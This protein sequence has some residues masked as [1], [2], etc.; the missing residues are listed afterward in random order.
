MNGP[1]FFRYNSAALYAGGPSP[2]SPNF[3]SLV[4]AGLE[5]IQS[6]N[7]SFS[8]PREDLFGWDGGGDQ[9]LIDRPRADL[10]FS[11]VFT[12]GQVER[13][14][15]FVVGALNTTSALSNLN[16]ER[17]YY[18]LFNQGQ[19]DLIG[20][21][22]WD[23][24]V[25]AF[26]NGVLTRYDFAA[27]VGQPTTCNA[28]V[29]CLNLAIQPSGTGQPLPAVYKQSGNY[30]TGLYALPFAQKTISEFAEAAPRNI[31]LTFDT[32]CAIGALLSGNNA[33]PLQSFGF[34]IDV[35]R[36]DIRS[37]GWA[38]PDTRSVTWP[39]TIN[40]NASAYLN[41]IQLDTLNRFG[42]PD[43]GLNFGVRFNNAC[44]SDYDAFTFQFNGAK[45]N[46][47]RFA[48]SI[49]S[50]ARVDL[51]WTM[52]IYDIARPVPNFFITSSGIAYSSIVFPEV[53]YVSGSSPLT[54]NLSTLCYLLVLSGPGVLNG[55]QVSVTDDPSTIVVRA[56]TTDGSD[57]QDVTITVT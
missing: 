33:C 31:V 44:N 6:T 13:N 57:S 54:F 22:G 27:A 35:P 53:D 17:N 23:N 50:L 52:K 11:W 10:S 19:Q 28:T 3:E 32:G 36:R 45:L 34:S 8:Y 43:S 4:T 41:A 49:G 25:M 55:N 21:S 14:I 24:K 46:S 42:C 37:M 15:G 7:V 40:L 16:T 12:S 5:G 39:I 38:Y 29:N 51:D 9:T 56:V 30:A 18:L 47:Q 2:Y 1:S 20:Y 26:G 48:A